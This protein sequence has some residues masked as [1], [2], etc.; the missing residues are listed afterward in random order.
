MDGV[1]NPVQREG[2]IHNFT[3]TSINVAKEYLF[4]AINPLQ[5]LLMRADSKFIKHLL[6][7][8]LLT[9]CSL[10]TKK[11]INPKLENEL[12][13][14]SE[15]SISSI[16]DNTR[17]YNALFK[18]RWTNK[19][20]QDWEAL[21]LENSKY[22]RCEYINNSIFEIKCL[23]TLSFKNHNGLED[24][25]DID[26]FFSGQSLEGKIKRAI[27]S[28]FMFHD[29]KAVAEREKDK[30][31]K[32]KNLAALTKIESLKKDTKYKKYYTTVKQKRI[33]LGM[34]EELLILSWGNPNNVTQSVGSWGVHK[35][36]IYESNYVYIEN[37]KITSWQSF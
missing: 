5:Y 14:A 25:I 18:R 24:S 11:A 1:A 26:F 21:R 28:N 37:G 30:K 12:K 20:F 27:N 31:V 36:Y 3:I 29:D 33:S 6:V 9:S 13:S 7:I 16:N 17:Y 8:F 23:Y 34:P 32:E 22:K 19:T 15:K 4:L 10:V 35:Q 2:Q